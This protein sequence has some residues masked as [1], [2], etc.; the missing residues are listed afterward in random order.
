MSSKNP[1]AA[2][3]AGDLSKI[4]VAKRELKRVIDQFDPKGKF[5]VIIFNDTVKAWKP[6]MM[7]ATKAMKADAQKFVAGLSAASSTNIYDALELAFK[8]AGMGARDKYYELGADT[9]FLLSDGSPTKP[10]GSP[11]DWQ[12]IIRACRQWNSLK[13]VKINTIGVGGAN[14][15]FMSTLASENGGKYVAR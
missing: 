10:D 11:D 13:R 12:K 6:G 1:G 4:A 8:I 14:V 7:P 2:P 5:D 15:A 3:K 9:I